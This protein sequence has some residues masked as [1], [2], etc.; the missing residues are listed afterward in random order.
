LTKLDWL[1]DDADLRDQLGQAAWW[2]ISENYDLKTRYLP[3]QINW[4][5]GLTQLGNLV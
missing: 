4:V 2:L 5:D 3:R 1:L